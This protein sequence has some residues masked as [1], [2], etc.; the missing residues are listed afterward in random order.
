MATPQSSEN[1]ARS[2]LT[3]VCLALAIAAFAL[4]SVLEFA[5]STI[6]IDYY[7]FWATGLAVERAEIRDV[8]DTPEN[9]RV[10]RI[11]FAAAQADA[12]QRGA[13]EQGT[14]RLAAA[15]VRKVFENYSTPLLYALFGMSLSGDYDRDLDRMAVFSSLFFVLGLAALARSLRYSLVGAALTVALCT[16]LAGPFIDDLSVGNVNRIQVGML[17]LTAYLLSL[18]RGRWSDALAGLLLGVAVL[19]KPN[20]A[21]CVVALLAAWLATGQA[22]RLIALGAGGVGA[23]ALALALTAAWFGSLQPWL[24]WSR[25]LGGL[26]PNWATDLGNQSLARVLHDR[27]GLANADWMPFVFLVAACAAFGAGRWRA[28]RADAPPETSGNEGLEALALGLGAAVSVL[29][30]KLA[31]FHYYLLLAPLAL[32][33]MRP[34]G[35]SRGVLVLA[36]LAFVVTMT[37]VPRKLLPTSLFDASLALNLGAT[38][39]LVLGLI[40][41]ARSAAVVRFVRSPQAS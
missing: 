13:R 4:S 37:D 10:G 24:V 30:T 33:L 16:M 2:A 11:Y 22:R 15:N 39:L 23:L 27:V 29:S 1:R 31:W 36:A 35:E 28:P 20:L 17:G 12:R 5:K 21:F 9:E 40:A 19:F 8:Y 38:T 25:R 3:E 7:L 26:M 32:W 6:G 14:R 18:R 41:A 34:R